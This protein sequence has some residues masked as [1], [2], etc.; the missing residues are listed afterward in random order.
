MLEVE[1]PTVVPGYITVY[2]TP[3]KNSF[4]QY[5]N[6][7]VVDKGVWEPHLDTDYDSKHVWFCYILKW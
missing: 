1:F 4:K 2:W 7:L 6:Q 3:T 5:Y